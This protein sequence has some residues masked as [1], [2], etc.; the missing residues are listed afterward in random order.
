MSETL[1][2]FKANLKVSST[3]L[4]SMGDEKTARFLYKITS[5]T[6]TTES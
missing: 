6:L 5:V 1:M 2:T 4:D 3:K